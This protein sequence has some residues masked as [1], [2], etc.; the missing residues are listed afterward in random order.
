MNKSPMKVTKR[1]VFLTGLFAS[2]SL[3]AAAQES[4]TTSDVVGMFADQS[5][6]GSEAGTKTVIEA[7]LICLGGSVG[8]GGESSH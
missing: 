5:F 6:V 4:Y 1:N 2:V 8:A 3:N 7:H